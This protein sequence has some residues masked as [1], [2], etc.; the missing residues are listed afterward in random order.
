MEV[1]IGGCLAPMEV[2]FAVFA[3]AGVQAQFLSLTKDGD[4]DACNKFCTSYPLR[5]PV[6]NTRKLTH[7]FWGSGPV[8][9]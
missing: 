6:R 5:L 2:P 7:W 8:G 3:H 9:C 1:P 4:R